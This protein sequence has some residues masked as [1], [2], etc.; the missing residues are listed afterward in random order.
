MWILVKYTPTCCCTETSTANLS[1]RTKEAACQFL[2]EFGCH[3]WTPEE[4]DPYSG[5]AV[6]EKY[7]GKK[8]YYYEL[9]RYGEIE[10]L[11]RVIRIL[12]YI[13]GEEGFESRTQPKKGGGIFG[14]FWASKMSE[15]YLE[16][17]R[18]Q[19]SPR[20]AK[21]KKRGKGK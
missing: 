21:R 12:D 19:L 6:L 3:D 18:L 14:W 11:P 7:K 10:N 9:N 4:F 5:D 1:F 13:K 20:F 17:E 16:I 2:D 15:V 8:Y